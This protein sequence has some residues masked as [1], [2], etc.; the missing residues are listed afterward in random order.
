MMLAVG[1]GWS[2]GEY[3]NLGYEF[4]NRGKRMD[5]A[6]HGAAHAVARRAGHLLSGQTLPL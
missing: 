2:K 5:E 1:I 4:S 3:A 6:H